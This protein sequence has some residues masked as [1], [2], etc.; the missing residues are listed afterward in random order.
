MKKTLA[1]LLPLLLLSAC[2]RPSTF[3]PADEYPDIFPDYIGVTIPEGLA[4]LTFAMADGRKC[5]QERWQQ[6]DTI[7]YA[8]K[9]WNKGAKIGTIYRP[10][11]V[12]ISHDPIDAYLAYRLIEPGYESWCDMGIYQRELASY[13]ETPIVTNR[14]NNRGCIN[15]HTFDPSHRDRMLFHA[16]G[17]GGGTVFIE[18]DDTQLINLKECGPGKQGVYPAWHPN[19]RWV[20]FS[21]NNTHQCFPLGDPQAVE[22]YDVASD[23]IL[24][25]LNNDSIIA[26]SHLNTEEIWETFPTWAPDGRTLYYCAAD[27][28]LPM[29]YDR[30]RLHYR[31]L[32]IGF[33]ATSG[34]FDAAPDTLSL[35]FPSNECSVSLPRISPDGRWLLYTLAAY[36]TFPIWHREADLWMLD[37]ETGRHRPCTELNSPDTESYHS[38]SSNGRWIVFSSRRL[39]GRYTRLFIAHHDGAGHFSKPFLLPQH[40]PDHNTLRMQ[41]YNIPE[42]VQSEIPP[43]QRQVKKMFK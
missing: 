32:R 36:G 42:F 17:A 41:S 13:R 19:G 9:A 39:D 27:S 24:M 33:D 31:L 7:W 29:P 5:E 6:G 1:S 43:L 16:R 37:L 11:P 23:I 20:V 38:W 2:H 26:P 30:S 3:T 21:S 8:V 14:A 15:C 40:R 28:V 4:P 34:T 35:P 10:F 12:Y 22:V 18:G 25:D